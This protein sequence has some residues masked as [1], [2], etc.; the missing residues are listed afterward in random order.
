MKPPAFTFARPS[1][2][3]QVDAA[4][5]S[6]GADCRILAG[7]QTLVPMLCRRQVRPAHVVDITGL[8]GERRAAE[9]ADDR[10][11]CGPLVRLSSLADDPVVRARLPVLPRLL[12]RVGTPAVRNRA[13][14]VG[15]LV[16][17][18]RASE[19]PALVVLLGGH[20]RVRT[21][22]GHRRVDLALAATRW[23]R[24]G[25]DPT[26]WV[27]EIAVRLPAA[28]TRM[29]F[30]E[31]SRRFGSRAI[32]GA[33]ASASP[34]PGGRARLAVAVFGAS[35]VPLRLDLGVV[36]EREISGRPGRDPLADRMAD[37]LAPLLDD[38]DDAHATGRYR[39]LVAPR[40][41]A[42]CLRAAMTGQHGDAS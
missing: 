40:V 33:V 21:P 13:T 29:A 34:A 31:L 24:T 4:L 42:R 17:A 37:T 26:G 3:E 32:A 38:V 35:P 22:D 12:A 6:R 27:D 39:R 25:P 9:H 1:T 30:V 10:L 11:V 14:L 5:T 7:G 36:E 15:N 28:G 23:L 41:A 19:L 8:T 16:A 20:A 18:D 2:R